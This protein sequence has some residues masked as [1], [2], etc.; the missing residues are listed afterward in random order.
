MTELERIDSYKKDFKIHT[1]K[2]LKCIITSMRIGDTNFISEGVIDSYTAIDIIF[3][4]TEWNSREIFGKAKPNRVILK[5]SIIYFILC[6]NGAS[7]SEVAR[8]FG[9]DHTTVI[10]SL[11][12]FEFELETDYYTQKLFTEILNNLKRYY[13]PKKLLTIQE[14]NTKYART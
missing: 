14:F 6:N 12:N 1:G 5:R 10:N 9:K 11:R 8:I 3:N 7:I 2:G 13:N 4:Y